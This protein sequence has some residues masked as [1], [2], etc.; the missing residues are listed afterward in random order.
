M[1]TLPLD[2]KYT[3]NA[4]PHTQILKSPMPCPLFIPL[5]IMNIDT[6]TKVDVLF[7]WDVQ[8]R[9]RKLQ[10]VHCIRT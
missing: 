9:P 7:W 10:D 2:M 6:R 8:M 4:H 5:Y 3:Q 1:Y